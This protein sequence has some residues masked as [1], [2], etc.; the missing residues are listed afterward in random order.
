M[1]KQLDTHFPDMT[2]Q[3]NKLRIWHLPEDMEIPKNNRDL[4]VKRNVLWLIRNLAVRNSGHPCFDS[5]MK[6]LKE[7]AAVATIT[8]QAKEASDNFVH[9]LEGKMD[10]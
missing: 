6:H 10:I 3:L 4:D 5:V 1:K 9:P 7:M 2:Q 8:A